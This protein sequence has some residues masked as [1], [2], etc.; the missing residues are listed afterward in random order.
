MRM[1]A[2]LLLPLLFSAAALAEDTPPPRLTG[3]APPLAADFAEPRQVTVIGQYAD[4]RVMQLQLK[5][6]TEIP[7]HA[8]PSRALVIVV[9]GRGHF[10]FDGEIVP[11]HERQ[12]LHMKPAE[13]HAVVAETDLE[14]LVVRLPA[15]G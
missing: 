4:T 7:S 3:L 12:V 8:A 14:L 13:P 1:F 15:E 11:L 5:A 10:D 2:S 6:G 9:S